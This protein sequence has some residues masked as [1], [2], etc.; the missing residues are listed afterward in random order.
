MDY[1]VVKF[2]NDSSLN[3]ILVAWLGENDYDMFEESPDGLN[4]YIVSDKFDENK[5][6][7]VIND[8]PDGVK[9]IRYESSLIKDQNWN[10]QWEK[11]FEPVLIAE[12]VYIRAPFHPQEKNVEY[13]IIIE[14]KMSFG[15]GHHSTTALMIE[16]ML[17]MN[18]KDKKVLD[19]G[20]GT[21][22]L[23][24]LAEMLGA[25]EITAIDVEEWAYL[26]SVENCERNNAANITVKRGDAS[27]LFNEKYGIILANINRNILLDDLSSYVKALK[28][29]GSIIMSGILVSDKEVINECAINNGLML[30]TEKTHQNWLAL[31]YK[32]S[33]YE[34]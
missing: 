30:V 11:N 6:A 8:I 22:V 19:M 4:A 1:T 13:E 24:I 12:K 29:N 26:N 23:A 31:H 10:A 20:C 34:S 27:L 7:E 25:K 17:E 2:Y 9:N 21:G 28:A 15:T 32:K 5:L 16:C 14:P 3:D 18:F 33:E